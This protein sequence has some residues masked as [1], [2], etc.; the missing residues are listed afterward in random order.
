MK[1]QSVLIK[2]SENL[3]FYQPINWLSNDLSFP[4][5]L[6]QD[7]FSIRVFPGLETHETSSVYYLQV[8]IILVKGGTVPFKLSCLRVKQS[9]SSVHTSTLSRSPNSVIEIKLLEGEWEGGEENQE[10]SLKN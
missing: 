4:E 1:K 2:L 5:N 9:I 6:V 3:L 7:G 8:L 10:N